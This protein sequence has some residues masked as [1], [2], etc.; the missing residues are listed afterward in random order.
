MLNTQ[1]FVACLAGLCIVVYVTF[2]VCRLPKRPT[3]RRRRNRMDLE[4]FETPLVGPSVGGPAPANLDMQS[5]VDFSDVTVSAERRKDYRDLLADAERV[6]TVEQRFAAAK[7][8]NEEH[9]MQSHIMPTKKRRE[10]IENLARRP[11][12]GRRTRSWRTQFSDPL[13]GDVVPKQSNKNWNMMRLGRSDPSKDLHPGAL[14]PVS[15]MD[16]RWLAEED[17][18]ENTF[19]FITNE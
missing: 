13:R 15:G 10:V 11:F 1:Q 2:L 4:N 9:G 18:P 19:D 14:G 5:I 12:C 17:V 6:Q 8:K 7:R 16:G 3:P